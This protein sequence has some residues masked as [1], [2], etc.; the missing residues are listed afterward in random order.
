LVNLIGCFLIGLCFSLAGRDLLLPQV[1]LLL[2][3]GFLGG[4]TTFSTCVLESTNFWAGGASL[5]AL[6]N[7]AINN[8][9]G[10]ILICLGLW[11]GKQI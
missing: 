8:L 10:L 9:G 11:L 2:M 7:L 3:T 4:L 6:T 5:A 1:K